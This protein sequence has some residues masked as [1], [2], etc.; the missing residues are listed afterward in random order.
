MKDA[1][2]KIDT[3]Q[4]VLLSIIEDMND[5]NGATTMAFMRRAVFQGIV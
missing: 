5:Q 4:N 2:G 1:D 3:G